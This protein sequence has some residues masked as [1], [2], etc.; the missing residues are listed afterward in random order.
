VADLVG[1][2]PRLRIGFSSSVSW[3]LVPSFSLNCWRLGDWG[4]AV[5]LPDGELIVWLVEEGRNGAPRHDTVVKAVRSPGH[6]EPFTALIVWP[7]GRVHD[8]QAPLG[9]PVDS[10]LGDR[11]K[12]VDENLRLT[13]QSWRDLFDESVDVPGGPA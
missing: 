10:G 2:A 9:Q 13:S 4:K 1:P 3:P 6:R 11:L 5:V 12:L 7:D 8:L